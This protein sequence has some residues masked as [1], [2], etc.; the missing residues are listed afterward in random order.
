VGD[1]LV[2]Y[3]FFYKGG[4]WGGADLIRASSGDEATGAVNRVIQKE[5]PHSTKVKVTVS[6]KNPKAIP[7]M[8]YKNMREMA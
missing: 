4:Y 2:A 8:L 1:Y 5:F 3:I 7:A 6:L